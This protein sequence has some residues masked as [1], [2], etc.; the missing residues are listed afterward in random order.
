[1]KIVHLNLTFELLE[2]REVD[3]V[4]G[5]STIK[6]LFK[7]E[8]HDHRLLF[9][10]EEG[11]MSPEEKDK[12][13]IPCTI[14]SNL[15]DKNG[16]IDTDKKDLYSFKVRNGYNPNTETTH[17]GSNIVIGYEREKIIVFMCD[18]DMFWYP[19]DTQS[20]GARFYQ[21]NANIIL[22]PKSIAYKGPKELEQYSVKGVFLCNGALQVGFKDYI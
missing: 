4:A 9:H 18:F 13:W 5:T 17:N 14:F 11:E 8:W 15:R 16:W 3:E 20:C 1:M 19:F 21:R 10:G 22:V 12:I 6:F 7:R 2:V